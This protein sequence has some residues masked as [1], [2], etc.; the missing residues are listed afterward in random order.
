MNDFLNAASIYLFIKIIL[1]I[2]IA[3]YILFAAVI[4]RQEELMSRVVEIPFS[5]LLRIVAIIHF[6]A[7]LAI[8]VLALLLL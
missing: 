8:F 4:V 1:L 3:F 6:V 5:P 2:L 7:S